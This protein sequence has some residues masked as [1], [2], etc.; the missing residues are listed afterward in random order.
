MKTLI[1]LSLFGL[2]ITQA[3]SAKAKDCS[4]AIYKTY[5]P[6]PSN[7]EACDDHGLPAEFF[8]EMTPLL[9]SLGQMGYKPERYD[10]C[11]NGNQSKHAYSLVSQLGDCT[12]FFGT[13]TCKL[14]VGLYDEKTDKP[15]YEKTIQTKTSSEITVHLSDALKELPKCSEL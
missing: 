2:M 10:Q 7:K 8:G 1:L 6:T 13:A 4:L 14:Y 5:L 9:L 12:Q 15:V 11:A 3:A